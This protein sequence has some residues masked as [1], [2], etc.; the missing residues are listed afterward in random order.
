MQLRLPIQEDMK[1][2]R[3]RRQVRSRAATFLG[4]MG[5]TAALGRAVSSERDPLVLKAFRAALLAPGG[6]R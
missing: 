4:R 6:G 1:G 2:W 3:Q 5:D